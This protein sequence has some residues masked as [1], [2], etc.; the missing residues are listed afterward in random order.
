M[1]KVKTEPATMVEHHAWSGLGNQGPN[2]G[3]GHD[4]DDEE[5]HDEAQEHLALLQQ[6]FDADPAG[7]DVKPKKLASS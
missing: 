1:T 5:E 3:P 6:V 2:N 4:D 7:G